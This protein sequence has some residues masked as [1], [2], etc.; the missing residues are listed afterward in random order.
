MMPD[1]DQQND[2][3][4]LPDLIEFN[5]AN[6]YLNNINEYE[7]LLS[8]ITT[9]ISNIYRNNIWFKILV[10]EYIIILSVPRCKNLLKSSYIIFLI[11]S[12]IFGVK[13]VLN[14]SIRFLTV[15]N[16]VSI[17]TSLRGIFTVE[18]I[19]NLFFVYI[20]NNFIFIFAI[21]TIFYYNYN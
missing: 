10:F 6:Y 12:D 11:E 19:C 17:D 16:R 9:R 20:K 8:L 14:D 13:F 7:H 4:S 1:Q 21:F 15:F 18:S 3:D 5:E 2:D